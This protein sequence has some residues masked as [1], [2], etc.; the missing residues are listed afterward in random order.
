VHVYIDIWVTV[1]I[2]E[3]S[4]WSVVHHDEPEVE[5]YLRRNGASGAAFD[6]LR[7]NPSG[8]ISWR[9]EFNGKVTNCRTEPKRVRV[10][11]GC[12]SP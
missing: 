7:A 9:G 4:F 5:D 8:S 1:V 6:S 10:T 12:S 2:C 3:A 11:I